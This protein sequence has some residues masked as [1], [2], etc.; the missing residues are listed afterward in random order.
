MTFI[1]P[2]ERE[3][4]FERY[5]HSSAYVLSF[6]SYSTPSLEKTHLHLV[7]N[8]RTRLYLIEGIPQHPEPLL[9]MCFDRGTPLLSINATSDLKTLDQQR[10]LLM[11]AK[12]YFTHGR[13]PFVFTQIT[14]QNLATMDEPLQD[15]GFD[16]IHNYDAPENPHFWYVLLKDTFNTYYPEGSIFVPE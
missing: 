7:V 15:L 5:T 4:W 2:D 13:N 14:Q 3:S 8:N 6:L 16:K 1:P 10:I 11:L 12:E 9:G